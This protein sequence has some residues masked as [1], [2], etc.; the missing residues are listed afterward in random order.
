M[1]IL[2]ADSGEGFR[3]ISGNLYGLWSGRCYGS[4]GGFDVFRAG[5]Q[6]PTINPHS[7][8]SQDARCH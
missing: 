3:E 7:K 5:P 2:G 6:N 4:F 1:Q 8:Y